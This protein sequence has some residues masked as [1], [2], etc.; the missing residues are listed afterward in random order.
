MIPFP[1]KGLNPMGAWDIREGRS[2]EEFVELSEAQKH[3][4][5]AEYRVMKRRA[6]MLRVP[7][8][9]YVRRRVEQAQGQATL[10]EADLAVIGD[11]VAA[12]VRE[13]VGMR[14]D[15]ARIAREVARLLEGRR[16]PPGAPP[17]A[18]EP[19]KVPVDDVQEM[20]ERILRRPE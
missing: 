13:E 14:V 9:T 4:L 6:R 7:L 19:A 20:L 18:A 12:R 3:R 16:G 5:K 11:E 2:A 15:P 1:R 17:P 10:G 8:Q